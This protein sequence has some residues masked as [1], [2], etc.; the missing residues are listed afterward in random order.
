[1]GQS[2][3]KT[4]WF[5]MGTRVAGVFSSG[6]NKSLLTLPLPRC[7]LVPRRV[8]L[9]P[10]AAQGSSRGNRDLAS[11]QRRSISHGCSF[12]PPARRSPSG[13]RTHTHTHTHTH[14]FA[15]AS[16]FIPARGERESCSF[17]DVWWARR[18]FAVG[19]GQ[20]QRERERETRS[21][22]GNYAMPASAPNR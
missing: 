21:T 22:R 16:L 12:S 2:S 11:M 3:R 14:T 15:A 13:T 19:Q 18:T 10:S 17:T 20:G 6:R 8:S 1:V 9:V 4:D 7:Q 5:S